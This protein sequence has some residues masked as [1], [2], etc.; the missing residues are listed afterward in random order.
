ME[1]NR[2]VLELIERKRQITEQVNE[3]LQQLKAMAENHEVKSE[4]F[5]IPLLLPV[6]D[7]NDQ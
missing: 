4:L 1:F 2:R 3:K 7:G 6:T 5:D